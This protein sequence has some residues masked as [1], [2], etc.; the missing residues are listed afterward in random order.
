M[1]G[2]FKNFYNVVAHKEMVM[3]FQTGMIIQM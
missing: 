1:L 2:V 3:M